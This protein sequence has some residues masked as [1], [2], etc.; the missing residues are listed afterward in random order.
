MVLLGLQNGIFTDRETGQIIRFKRV[1]VGEQSDDTE[2][3]K[4][5]SYKVGKEC[6]VGVKIGEQCSLFFDKYGKVVAVNP[7]D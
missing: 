6:A 2:G 1:H 7:I 4:V 3:M 5:S